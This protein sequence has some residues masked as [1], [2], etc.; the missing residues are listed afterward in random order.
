MARRIVLVAI[1][2]LGLA[3]P[4]GL[5]AQES[6]AARFAAGQPDLVC[7]HR[8]AAME[9]APE[10]TLAWIE[11]GIGLGVDMLHINPQLT[12]DGQYVL[13]HDATLNRMTDVE[14]VYP[15][16]PPGGP[17]RAQ[18]A[19]RDYVRDYTLEE[20][21]RLRIVASEEAAG[22]PVPTLAEAL[23]LVDGRALVM[24]GLKAYEVESL[25]GALERFDPDGLLL[26]DLYYPGT[27]QSKLKSLS[28]ATG[29]G[30]AVSLFRS[31]D[32]LADLDGIHGQLG[33]ALK[34]VTLSRRDVTPAVLDRM[35]GLGLRLGLSGWDASEDYA[36]AEKDDLGPWQAAIA[37][38]FV[39]FTDRPDLVL[40]LL[41]R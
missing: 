15:D 35:Q 41:G 3:A 33:E 24:L 6:V 19:G 10:N 23:D 25:A 7:A 16:G 38:G 32:P 21:R 4:Q 29:I 37:L 39:M 1:A 11:A 36:L 34:L 12:A 31:T 9:G 17:T 8:S 14:T 22:Q 5:P 26:F 28:E 40:G 18:R 30:V 2:I 13:M 27:D 20:I